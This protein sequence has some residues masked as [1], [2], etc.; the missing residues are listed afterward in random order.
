[1]SEMMDD[2]KRRVLKS[3]FTGDVSKGFDERRRLVRLLIL[4]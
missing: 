1:M 3:V 4:Q 2:A